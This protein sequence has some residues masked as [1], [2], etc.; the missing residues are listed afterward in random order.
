MM[1]SHYYSDAIE[2]GRAG[3][4]QLLK[5]SRMQDLISRYPVT[6]DTRSRIRAIDFNC[7]SPFYYKHPSIVVREPA[8]YIAKAVV[9]LDDETIK[10]F[11]LLYSVS[12]VRK[13]LYNR[14]FSHLSEMALSRLGIC[15]FDYYRL[16]DLYERR[17]S[18]IASLVDGI[19]DVGGLVSRYTPQSLGGYY[20]G[21][22]EISLAIPLF[23]LNAGYKYIDDLESFPKQLLLRSADMPFIVASSEYI[24][25]MTGEDYDVVFQRVLQDNGAVGFLG[26]I[27]LLEKKDETLKRLELEKS[28]LEGQLAHKKESIRQ[29]ETEI[30]LLADLWGKDISESIIQARICKCNDKEHR[31][32]LYKLESIVGKTLSFTD[33]ISQTGLPIPFDNLID[34]E[35]KIVISEKEIPGIKTVENLV[36]CIVSHKRFI[37]EFVDAVQQGTIIESLRDDDP[38]DLETRIKEVEAFYRYNVNRE[39]IHSID[40]LRQFLFRDDIL[41]ERLVSGLVDNLGVEPE[42]VTMESSFTNDL[43]ADSL[44]YVELL[45]RAETEFGIKIPDEETSSISTVKDLYDIIV[46]KTADR[47]NS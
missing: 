8:R 31:D 37:K 27:S 32:I 2:K 36:D 9:D 43:G 46:K 18:G 44:D 30:D 39:A 40:D 47:T 28:M 38:Y 34:K 45:M 23:T 21:S 33:S 14:F 20:V 42:D 3:L 19:I 5:N 12:S 41:W 29:Q 1:M 4:A 24:S 25:L 16:F 15:R 17:D 6:D 7:D 22:W 11:L 10:W 35:F 13:R 26:D